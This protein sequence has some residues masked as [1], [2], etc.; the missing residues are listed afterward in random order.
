MSNLH[1]VFQSG[2]TAVITGAASGIGL[3]AAKAFAKL[4]LNV[5]LADLAGERLQEAAAEV[6]A[7]A[8]LEG[9]PFF[10]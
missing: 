6:R 4:G 9:E 2:N 7:A 10:R 8:T 3:A 1:P 5:V